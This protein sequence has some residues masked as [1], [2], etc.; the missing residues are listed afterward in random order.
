M[1]LV[2]I[3]IVITIGIRE[4]SVAITIIAKQR[5]MIEQPIDTHRRS[6]LGIIREWPDAIERIE[7]YLYILWFFSLFSTVSREQLKN[8]VV[9]E[10]NDIVNV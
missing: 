4:L 10:P 6:G 9:Q 2:I 5:S 8:R 3:K 7:S 1:K